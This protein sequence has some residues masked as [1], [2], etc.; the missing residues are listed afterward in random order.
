M[1][2]ENVHDSHIVIQAGGFHSD[3]ACKPLQR[4][5]RLYHTAY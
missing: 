3:L 2:L 5:R 4:L 1:Y